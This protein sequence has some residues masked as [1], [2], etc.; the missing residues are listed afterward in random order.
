M[1]T[2][3]R[4]YKT[5]TMKYKSDKYHGQKEKMIPAIKP[6][7]SC[8]ISDATYRIMSYLIPNICLV[9]EENLKRNMNPVWIEYSTLQSKLKFEH[10]RMQQTVIDQCK[11]RCEQ[12]EKNAYIQDI[13]YQQQNINFMKKIAINKCF[14]NVEDISFI[15]NDYYKKKKE[16]HKK[17][18]KTP[19][20]QVWKQIHK[21]IKNGLPFSESTTTLDNLEKELFHFVLT[22][23]QKNLTN[24][25]PYAIVYAAIKIIN[26]PTVPF[27][28]LII[29][30]FE[31][32]RD[33]RFLP[34]EPGKKRVKN[35]KFDSKIDEEQAYH[36][37]L[38]AQSYHRQEIPNQ[39]DATIEIS[40]ENLFKIFIKYGSSDQ[41][42][43][44]RI[45][46]NN[47]RFFKVENDTVIVFNTRTLLLNFGYGLET[48]P[49]QYHRMLPSR[50]LFRYSVIYTL[51]ERDY[52][53][54]TDPIIQAEEDRTYGFIAGNNEKMRQNL[55]YEI[56]ETNT[57]HFEDNE[58]KTEILVKMPHGR[59]Q[60]TIAK[61]AK[62]CAATVNTYLRQHPKKKQRILS[63][64][65]F[66]NLN[67]TVSCSSHL[68]MKY[69]LAKDEKWFTIF[70][71]QN[72]YMVA[73]EHISCF[74]GGTWSY[75]SRVQKVIK[76][77]GSI[78]HV[79]L[80]NPYESDMVVVKK[81]TFTTNSEKRENIKIQYQREEK[82]RSSCNYKM[83]LIL[84]EFHERK[85]NNPN[86]Q[87]SSEEK[88]E[89][90]QLKQIILKTKIEKEKL[91]EKHDRYKTFLLSDLERTTFNRMK[92]TRL[93]VK[94]SE[95]NG[96][97]TFKP[98]L[99]GKKQ[100]YEIPHQMVPAFLKQLNM[101]FFYDD[102]IG[103]NTVEFSFSKRDVE[104][105]IKFDR[106]LLAQLRIDR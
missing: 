27:L 82:K 47:K 13:L 95:E 106:S 88:H 86:A 16:N 69:K 67:Q 61:Q 7:T 101:Q 84:K 29:T 66:T 30:E 28:S 65:E 98:K 12:L 62:V 97:M 1:K 77:N 64:G 41:P 44:N 60:K 70:E 4:K 35:P 90:Q 3:P 55:M 96:D 49:K 24:Y 17:L 92:K 20:A 23:S 63:Y 94:I 76:E 73:D 58:N 100:K 18:N 80:F 72:S 85:K 45:I 54:T 25:S 36:L 83:M 21:T 102:G 43:F 50:R 79:D 78:F 56:L 93:L 81:V 104:Q 52:I 89:L 2:E 71:L 15:I 22:G 99:H 11:K 42:K 5:K 10:R 91:K 68:Y 59:S 105:T 38:A 51:A 57:K 9:F 26:Y 31:K 103:G 87:L 53:E 48:I 14:T 40:K 33:T 8:F 75:L 46:N 74:Y 32:N 19:F 39:L 37:W 6:L 34:K